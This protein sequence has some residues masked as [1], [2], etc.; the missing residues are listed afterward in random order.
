[1]KNNNRSRVSLY[2]PKELK[3]FISNQAK[4]R[5]ISTNAILTILVEKELEKKLKNKG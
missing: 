5:G 1:M 3:E 4:K 2:L